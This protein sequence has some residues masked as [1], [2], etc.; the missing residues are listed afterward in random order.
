MVAAGAVAWRSGTVAV[1]ITNSSDV[2]AALANLSPHLLNAEIS[3]PI[4]VYRPQGSG[5]ACSRRTVTRRFQLNMDDMQSFAAVGQ[6]AG[7]RALGSPIVVPPRGHVDLEIDVRACTGN[8]EFSLTATLVPQGADEAVSLDLGR[9][10][11]D[12]GAD[13]T[14]FYTGTSAATRVVPACP[15]GAGT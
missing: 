6:V 13:H 15:T 4:W 5:D 12:G 3:S 8:Y 1:R 11:V 2:P 14:D 9:F 10:R 7:P